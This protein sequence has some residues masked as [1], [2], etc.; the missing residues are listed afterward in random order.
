MEKTYAKYHS[1][2]LV[3]HYVNVVQLSIGD[4]QCS[5]ACYRNVHF[6]NHTCKCDQIISSMHCIAYLKMAVWWRVM[7]ILVMNLNNQKLYIRMVDHFNLEATATKRNH[8]DS[9]PSYCTAFSKENIGHE[10]LWT[11]AFF[12]DHYLPLL[13]RKRLFPRTRIL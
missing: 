3:I 4:I 13:Y 7:V 2:I 9:F 1:V 5:Q 10:W 6:N 12:I 11:S 8:P